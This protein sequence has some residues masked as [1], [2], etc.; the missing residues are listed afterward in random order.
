MGGCSEGGQFSVRLFIY[1]LFSFSNQFG[2]RTGSAFEHAGLHVFNVCRIS[3]FGVLIATND[4][5][6]RGK[7]SGVWFLGNER[8]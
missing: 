4:S 8:L 3:C 7:C 2:F 6:V 5:G 1:G